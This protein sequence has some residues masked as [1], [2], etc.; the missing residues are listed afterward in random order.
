[1]DR[2]PNVEPFRA[3]GLPHRQGAPDRPGGSVEAGEQ[4]IP[5]AINLGSPKL[6]ELGTRLLDMPSEEL[7]PR[8]VAD[9]RHDGRR[10]D[11][12]HHQ[13][14]GERPIEEPAVAP[15]PRSSARPFD[16]DGRL[17][18]DGVAVMAGWDVIHIVGP[19]LE[20]RAIAEHH[21]LAA[22]ECH[23]DVMALTPLP[24]GDCAH[25]VRPAPAGVLDDPGD[26]LLA[27]V[28]QILLDAREAH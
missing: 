2:C 24:A 1:V 12:V 3:S 6:G 11:D 15:G 10:L 20:H 13:Q 16:H 5:G 14:G 17:V 23:A 8:T 26:D 7:A 22:G 28:D 21:A 19:E 27:D 4:A 9:P 25:I 18:A